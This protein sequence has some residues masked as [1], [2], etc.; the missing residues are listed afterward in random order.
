MKRCLIA[1]FV[2][3]FVIN[4]LVF[5]IT[6]ILMWLGISKHCLLESASGL[7]YSVIYPIH[8]IAKP[9]GCL[10]ASFNIPPDYLYLVM[11]QVSYFVLGIC[12]CLRV[13]THETKEQEVSS[14][15]THLRNP[16]T[17]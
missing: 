15:V 10:L 6:S 1:V 4:F 17:Y 13:A 8:A 14:Q 11:V 2:V 3:L 5:T 9:Y 7:P 16:L 12:Y